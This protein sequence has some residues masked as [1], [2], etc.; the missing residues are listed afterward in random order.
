MIYLLTL[1]LL[2]YCA[3]RYN[4]ISYNTRNYNLWVCVITI[5]F[6]AIA[7]LRFEIGADTT[8]SYMPSY[9]RY[10]SIDRLNSTDFEM[11]DYQPGWVVF[12][13]LCKYI[14]PSF[15][16]FQF[17]HALILNLTILFF[18]KRN[19]KNVLVAFLVYYVMNYLEFNTECL[20]EAMAVSCSLIAFEFYKDKRYFLVILFGFLAFNFHVSAIGALFI[21]LL[22]NIKFTKKSFFIIL[23][24]SLLSPFLYQIL[25]DQTKLL[26]ALT[27]NQEMA[28][29]Y[30]NQFSQTLNA[31]Y[32]IMHVFY[33]IFIPMSLAY[34]NIKNS[35]GKYIGFAYAFS[36]LQM[37][38]VFSYAFYRLSNYIAPFYWL[39]IADCA[40]V[41][42]R[43]K[44]RGAHNLAFVVFVCIGVY[45]CQGR[46]LDADSDLRINTHGQIYE[47]Y[48]PYKSWIFED[49]KRW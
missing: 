39:M 42:L 43:T 11:T 14:S 25:P 28:N 13:S 1:F 20:R 30:N 16:T 48:F 32:Y 19:N 22:F 6:I 36:I 2:I 3:L 34:Y 31:N 46:L 9:E 12:C 23:S 15:Y 26:V 7:A 24:I 27:R 45:V 4:G 17:I 5:L 21:P 29:Y 49:N 8:Y 44:V 37:L 41:Y 40:R 35:D 10:P 18:L 33:Y 38:A 47:R